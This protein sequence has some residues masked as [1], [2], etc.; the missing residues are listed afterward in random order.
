MRALS[1]VS[2]QGRPNPNPMSAKLHCFATKIAIRDSFA[3]GLE[4]FVM[5]KLKSPNLRVKTGQGHNNI[6]KRKIFWKNCTF[7]P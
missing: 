4:H 5:K 3:L 7:C 6:L 2:E 1:I